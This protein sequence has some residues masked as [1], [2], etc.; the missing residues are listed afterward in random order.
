LVGDNAGRGTVR[1][2]KKKKTDTQDKE[3]NTKKK[4]TFAGGEWEDRPVI[5][6]GC[7]IDGKLLE[8]GIRARSPE[9]RR[10]GKA[11]HRKGGQGKARHARRNNQGI[12]LE[13]GRG[14]A[15][16]PR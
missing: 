5:G 14:E 12:F 11:F 3:G 15:P 7:F 13:K 6:L 8:K 1:E 9:G 2:K 10:G 4:K 16:R